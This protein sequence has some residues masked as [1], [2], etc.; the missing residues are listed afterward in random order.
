MGD[1]TSAKVHTAFISSLAL[2]LCLPFFVVVA[3]GVVVVVPGWSVLF[4][5]LYLVAYLDSST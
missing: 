4:A 1:S 5:V 2:F 3:V